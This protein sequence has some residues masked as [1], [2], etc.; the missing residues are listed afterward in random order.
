M[1]MD[2]Y[3]RYGSSIDRLREKFKAARDASEK[4]SE[5]EQKQSPQITDSNNNVIPISAGREKGN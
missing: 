2:L 1:S 3:S 4:V 5:P